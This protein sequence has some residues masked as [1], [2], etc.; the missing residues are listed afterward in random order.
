MNTKP[1]W[2]TSVKLPSFPSLT[3]NLEVDVVIIGAGLT[4]ITAAHLL[5]KEGAKVAL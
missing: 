2:Q 4:G 3:K 1:Y 5:K